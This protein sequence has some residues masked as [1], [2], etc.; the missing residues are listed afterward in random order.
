MSSQAKMNFDDQIKELQ[1]ERN[2]LQAQV[3]EVLKTRAN[4]RAEHDISQEPHK[5]Q[6]KGLERDLSIINQSVHT[7]TATITSLMPLVTPDDSKGSSP[8]KSTLPRISEDEFFV[9]NDTDIFEFFETLEARL[10]S[11]KTPK[12]DWFRILGLTT[13]DSCLRWVKTHILSLSKE[14][15][16]DEAKKLFAQEYTTDDYAY[17]CRMKLLDLAQGSK[18]GADFMREVEALATGCEQSL[19]EKF[20]LHHLVHKQLSKTYHNA[21]NATVGKK[22]RTANFAELKEEIIFLD[23]TD[24][25]MYRSN[26]YNKSNGNN[27]NQHN[28]NNGSRKNGRNNKKSD[29]ESKSGTPCEICGLKNHT[30]SQHR[31]RNRSSNRPSAAADDT[32]NLSDITCHKCKQ[33]GHYANRCPN[34]RV[35]DKDANTFDKAKIEAKIR[36]LQEKDKMEITEDKLAMALHTM[37]KTEGE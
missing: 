4:L 12:K 17:T 18:T 21:L 19:T 9:P 15:S 36:V 5:T 2:D 20:F 30:T 25:T 11:Y 34:P 35:D 24:T 7:L 22:V 13:K 1:L 8:H 26:N 10:L 33:K 27:N 14:P 3:G 28:N 37:S 16:W 23:G 6:L 31:P 32:N 29:N